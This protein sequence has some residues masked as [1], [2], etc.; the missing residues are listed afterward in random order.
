[1]M[2]GDG[3]EGRLWSPLEAWMKVWR[4]WSEKGETRGESKGVSEKKEYLI[5]ER[6]NGADSS[7]LME[8]ISFSF[9]HAMGVTATEKKHII[10]QHFYFSSIRTRSNTDSHNF[11][12]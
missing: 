4:F 1:M 9:Y 7:I 5:S 2:K 11:L 6:K 12:S 3:D 8:N 10:F